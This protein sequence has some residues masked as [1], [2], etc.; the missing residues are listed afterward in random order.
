MLSKTACS[1]LQSQIYEHRLFDRFC[2]ISILQTVSLTLTRPLLC[3]VYKVTIRYNL[4][5]RLVTA[6][7]CYGFMH[8]TSSEKSAS[9]K[10]D[11]SC[12]CTNMSQIVA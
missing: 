12:F 7:I 5:F 8:T 3:V 4:A 2:A 9:G 10:N 6:G 11:L 1:S